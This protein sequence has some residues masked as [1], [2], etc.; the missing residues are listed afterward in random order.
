MASACLS[1]RDLPCAARQL[2]I[3]V[4]SSQ[5]TLETGAENKASVSV[6]HLTNRELLILKRFPLDKFL[7]VTVS[8]DGI[9]RISGEKVQFSAQNLPYE[10]SS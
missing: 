10:A 1:W 3:L 5:K 6:L 8:S 7:N 9:E 2:S 4:H